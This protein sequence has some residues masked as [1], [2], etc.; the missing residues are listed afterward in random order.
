MIRRDIA[1]GTDH[2]DPIAQFE[3]ARACCKGCRQRTGA[4]GFQDKLEVLRRSAHRMP[5][6]VIRDAN[7]A[8][9]GVL[10]DRKGH[11]PGGIGLQCIAQRRTGGAIALS[12]TERQ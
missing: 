6:F 1:P 7:R 10:Q 4:T 12:L 3:A 8:V 9:Q 5:D 11:G 2:A